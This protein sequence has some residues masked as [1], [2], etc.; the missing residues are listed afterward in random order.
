[1]IADAEKYKKD[2]EAHRERIAALNSLE[3]YCFNM[4][5]MINDEKF[6]DEINVEDK[7]KITK[8][9]D[10]AFKWIDSN[11]V[12]KKFCYFAFLINIYFRI[13]VLVS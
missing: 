12:R 7:K 11:P 6:A 10:E 3:S 2:D 9:I 1:M 13:N 5:T 8:A 4:K